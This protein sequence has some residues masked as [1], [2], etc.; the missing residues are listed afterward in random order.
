MYPIRKPFFGDPL[1]PFDMVYKAQKQ[2]HNELPHHLHDR[3]ELVY[4]YKGKGTFFIDNTFYDK[5]A[6]DLFIIPG[7]TIHCSFPDPIEP[8]V[9]SAVFF[10]PALAQDEAVNDSYSAL[11]CFT[12]ARRKKNYKVELTEA[13]SRWVEIG[14]EQINDELHQ[15]ASGFHEAV[16]LQLRQLLLHVNRYSSEDSTAQDTN[17]RIGPSWLR[18][19]IKAIDEHPEFHVGLSEFAAQSSVSPAHFSRVFRQFTGMNLT[20]YVNAKRIIIA[21]EMLR[22]T[23]ENIGVIAERCGFDCLPHFHRIFKSLTNLTP[24]V[25]RK[26]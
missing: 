10:A 25:Y 7:D 22:G 12:I 2:P 9:S 11:R 5:K 26:Q 3:Y 19:S 1:F 15:Q 4:V 6:G 8:I 14:M 16:I 23:E 18:K 13:L 21:K 20:D 24:G 17:K